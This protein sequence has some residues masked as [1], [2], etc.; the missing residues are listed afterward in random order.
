MVFIFIKWIIML[1]YLLFLHSSKKGT[2]FRDKQFLAVTLH[3][4]KYILA[5]SM[6]VCDVI[7]GITGSKQFKYPYEA[8]FSAILMN[9]K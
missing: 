9:I 3:I 8:M 6:N 1:T 5:V 4:R 7:T 2:D